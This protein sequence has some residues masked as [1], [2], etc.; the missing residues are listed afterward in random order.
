MDAEN[1]E[2]CLID[3]LCPFGKDIVK[4]ECDADD[5]DNTAEDFDETTVS[6]SVPPGP[7]LEDTVAEEEPSTN[8]DPRF[9]LEGK[10]VYKARYLNQIFKDFKTPGL[11]DRLKHVVN[12]P[13]YAVKRDF[14]LDFVNDNAYSDEPRLRLDSPI[15]TLLK[16]EG[17]FFVCVREVNNIIWDSKHVEQVALGVLF[18]PTIQIFHQILFLISATVEDDPE[19]KNDWH[20]TRKWGLSHHVTGQLV[21]M[22]SPAICTR[23]PG[24]P[25]YLF[26]SDILMAIGSS[27]LEHLTS[28]SAK[29]LAEV[30]RSN[31]FPYRETSSKTS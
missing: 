15:A 7:D 26:E 5:Y 13:C 17:H 19:E 25:F 21:E 29:R 30:K 6:S 2:G 27:L 9:D 11:C 31:D 24:K 23:D 12:V 16:C 28:E 18:D 14:H 20:W 1:N 22:L 3:I 8:H 4:A 10:K